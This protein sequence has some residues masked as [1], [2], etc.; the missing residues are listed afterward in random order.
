MRRALNLVKAEHD[1]VEAE[2]V[3]SHVGQQQQQQPANDAATA[4]GGARRQSLFA[5]VCMAAGPVAHACHL[6]Y[7]VSG[8]GR[9]ERSPLYSWAI[10][11]VVG[12]RR[13][14]LDE[15]GTVDGGRRSVC[16][17][18]L[19]TSRGHSCLGIGLLHVDDLRRACSLVCSQVYRV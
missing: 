8:L 18:S 16:W 9:R 4:E 10:A 13:G 14:V 19:L 6:R 7:R 12:H 17:P 2:P 3:T 5:T 1:V 11:E 15:V